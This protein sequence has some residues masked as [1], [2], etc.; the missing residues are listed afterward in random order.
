M[1]VIVVFF[2]D[3]S[4]DARYCVIM[5]NGIRIYS[6]DPLWRQILTD[7]NAVVLDAQSVGCIDFDELNIATPVSPVELKSAIL[8]ACDYSNII[9]RV[10]GRD[11]A[12]P[13]MQSQIV[14]M[15][16]K[17]GPMTIAELKNALG[18]SPDIATHTIDNAIYHL[19]KTYGREFIVN[20]NGAYAIG[21]L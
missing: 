5:L 3:M 12:M 6:S 16:Y 2:M 13:R 19:R 21:K 1:R 20:N 8:A 18:F 10:F 4:R 17:N 7:F 11:V 9:S 14:A 15:L